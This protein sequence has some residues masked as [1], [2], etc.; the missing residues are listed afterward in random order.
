MPADRVSGYIE[1]FKTS[2]KD[3]SKPFTLLA[4]IPIRDGTQTK[5]ETAF[6]AAIAANRSGAG[7]LAYDLNRETAD[8]TRYVVYERWKSLS[9]L[10]AHLRMPYITKLMAVTDE[11]LAVAPDFQVLLP[12]GE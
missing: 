11:V 5:F 7:L 10:E 9:A 4:R 12:A 2:L 3:P 1:H 8:G 6:A